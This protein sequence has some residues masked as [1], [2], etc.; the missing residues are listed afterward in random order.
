M[1]ASIRLVLG[2]QRTHSLLARGVRGCLL[3]GAWFTTISLAPPVPVVAA[4]EPS[5]RIVYPRSGDVFPAR[6][7]VIVQIEVSGA[8]PD[9]VGVGVRGSLPQELKTSPPYAMSVTFPA[10][11]GSVEIG[12]FARTS[13]GP[14]NASVTVALTPTPLPEGTSL[15]D[16]R[17]RPTSLA[18]PYPGASY[19]FSVMGTLSDGSLLAMRGAADGTTYATESETE[20]VV[21]VSPTGTVTAVAAG[22]DR[23]RVTNGTTTVVVSVKVENAVP[24]CGNGR[25]DLDEECDDGGTDSG[26]G[27]SSDCG[28]E[29]STTTTPPPSS[30]TTTSLSS[31]T[32]T[33]LILGCGTAGLPALRCA[34]AAWP[35]SECGAVKLPRGLERNFVRASR[36]AMKLDA[37]PPAQ[38]QA[39]KLLRK[40]TT[41]LKAAGRVAGSKKAKRLGDGCV[42]AILALVGQARG[43]LATVTP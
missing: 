42:D 20:D 15:T 18:L 6:S 23:I 21:R 30:T 7:Q 35:P 26:D 38:R 19:V 43:L 32:P 14:L 16:L 10:K 8:E 31:T 17:V 41:T 28:A 33:T 1:T 22:T 27:C 24:A 9:A 2:T 37:G 11:V 25:I 4:D 40:L 29:S 5:L 36:V 3:A 39:R 34:L 13:R 12:A